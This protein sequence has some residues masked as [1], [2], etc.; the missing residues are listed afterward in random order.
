MKFADDTHKTKSVTVLLWTGVHNSLGPGH[1]LLKH[2][3][4]KKRGAARL[5][6][7]YRAVTFPEDSQ[8]ATT[9]FVLVS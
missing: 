8:T 6:M 7:C 1:M 9:K 2:A 3:W 4:K 5:G